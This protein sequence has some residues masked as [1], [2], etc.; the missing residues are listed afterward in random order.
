MGLLKT[1]LSL[2]LAPLTGV[3]ALAEQLQHLAEEQWYDP[4]RIRL[5][6]EGVAAARQQ[7]DLSDA[8][9]DQHEEL[10]L[11]QLMVA[12]HRVREGSP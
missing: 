5:E 7:G 4:A 11:Q 2:P 10:L 8:E 1:V 12:T 9:A 6:L 3:V